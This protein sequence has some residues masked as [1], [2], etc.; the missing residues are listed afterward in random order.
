MD[1]SRHDLSVPDGRPPRCCLTVE[2]PSHSMATVASPE[3]VSL[4]AALIR[5]RRT[6][7]KGDSAA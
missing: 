1:D 2:L 4:L 7:E 3:L 5:R 6:Q